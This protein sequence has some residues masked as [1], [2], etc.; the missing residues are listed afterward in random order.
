M[1]EDNTTN[2][3]YVGENGTFD[4]RCP[5]CDPPRCPCC[6]R[7]YCR[8]RPPWERYP[9][10]CDPPWYPYPDWQTVTWGDSE[11]TSSAPYASVG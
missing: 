10:P 11:G 2:I 1:S 3:Y 6:G 7:P 9:Q 5:Y 4:C 8:P